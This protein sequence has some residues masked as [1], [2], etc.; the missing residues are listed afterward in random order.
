MEATTVFGTNWFSEE[1]TIDTRVCGKVT[2]R[3]IELWEESLHLALQQIESGG[4]FRIMVDLFGFSPNNIETH[5]RFRSIIP[6]TLSQYGWK[7]GYVD[8]FNEEAE[9]LQYVN[10]RDIKCIAAAHA[11]QDETKIGL[12]QR[13]YSRYNEHFFTDPLLARKWLKELSV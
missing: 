6:V 12:Y 8:L 9:K 2:F 13:S 7:V 3:D 5:K 11:H 1:K 10:T 4:V